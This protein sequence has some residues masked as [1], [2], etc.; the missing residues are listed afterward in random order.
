MQLGQ[1]TQFLATESIG[2]LKGGTQELRPLCISLPGELSWLYQERGPGKGS[3]GEVLF[4][5]CFGPLFF[6]VAMGTFLLVSH[7]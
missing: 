3:G 2:A 4:W 5:G 1:K 6:L 7:F